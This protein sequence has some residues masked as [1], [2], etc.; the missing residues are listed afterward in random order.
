MRQVTYSMGCTLDGYVV[1]PDG[2]FDWSVPDE[3]VFAQHLHDLRGTSVH[4]LGRRLHE[5]MLYWETDGP[6]LDPAELEW[7][8]MWR[9]LPKVVFSSTLTEVRGS[10]TRLAQGSLAEEIAQLR[11]ES[12]TGEI[13]VGGAQLA[14]EAA[15][16]D[17]IDE[18]RLFVHP[19]L[20]GGG[21]TFFPELERQVPLELISSLAF[22]SGVVASRYRVVR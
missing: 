14:A 13:A 17:L 18:Y 19:V 5:T 7:G 3:E 16:L 2:G 12:D 8:R 22:G 4:L 15:E 6:D 21:R 11:A 1:G 20:V 9:A 10:N